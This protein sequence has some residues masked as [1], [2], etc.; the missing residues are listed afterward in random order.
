VHCQHIWLAGIAG[1]RVVARFMD[2]EVEEVLV[3]GPSS[4]WCSHLVHGL[5]SHEGL[6]L[7]SWSHSGIDMGFIVVVRGVVALLST[8][9]CRGCLWDCKKE[10]EG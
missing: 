7:G 2:V 6:C 10:S 5:S 3:F 1:P 9:T 8:W 4:D